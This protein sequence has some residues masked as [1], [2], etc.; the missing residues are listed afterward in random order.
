MGKKSELFKNPF[1]SA[2]VSYIVLAF[3]ALIYPTGWVLLFSIIFS[4]V[5]SDVILNFF[6]HGG[7]GWSKIFTDIEFTCKGHAFLV[8]LIGIVVGTILSS[9]IADAIL[10]YAKTQLS[11][12][13]AILLTDLLVMV[14]VLGDL[15]WRFYTR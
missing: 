3:V 13:Y 8:F 1:F 4:F 5:L 2:F 14:A 9:L 12:F 6:I 7:S 10:Q 11:W 15:E